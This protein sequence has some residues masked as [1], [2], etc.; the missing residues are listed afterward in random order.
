MHD[1]KTHASLVSWYCGVNVASESGQRGTIL[2]TVTLQP[3]VSQMVSPC[4]FLANL[5][6]NHHRS[7]DGSLIGTGGLRVT[8]KFAHKK[9]KFKN[10]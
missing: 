8:H 6:T 7:R 2:Y 1:T 4:E 9:G 10:F 3:A 5:I